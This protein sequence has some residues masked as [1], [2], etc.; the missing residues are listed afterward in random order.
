M[1]R[2]KMDLG[3]DVSLL[4]AIFPY[5]TVDQDLEEFLGRRRSFEADPF[6]I[7]E[8]REVSTHSPISATQRRGLPL[9]AHRLLPPFPVA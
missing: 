8:K 5:S 9:P 6:L 7:K 4:L 1:S 2:P 3:T